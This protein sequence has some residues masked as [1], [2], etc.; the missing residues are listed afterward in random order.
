MDSIIQIH[1]LD[2]KIQNPQTS[3]PIDMDSIIQIHKLD[4]KIQNP[5]T[6]SPIDVDSKI[7]NTSMCKLSNPHYIKNTNRTLFG[8]CNPQSTY[9][10]MTHRNRPAWTVSSKKFNSFIFVPLIIYDI[11]ICNRLFPHFPH[12]PA[13]THVYMRA[14]SASCLT[15]MDF[16]IQFMYFGI[17]IHWGWCW[18]RLWIME[19]T[20]FME[21]DEIWI[22][23]NIME[24]HLF[25]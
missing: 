17:H 20:I 12:F 10:N 15:I 14:R 2:S 24:M 7:H 22:I 9:C 13:R 8:F 4:S 16:R 23:F 18:W 11:A 3:S 21:K 25:F 5:Q 6:S 19:Y 1:K